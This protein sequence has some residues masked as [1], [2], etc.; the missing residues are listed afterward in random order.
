[1]CFNFLSFIDLFVYDIYHTNFVLSKNTV[2]SY[3]FELGYFLTEFPGL[4]CS[5]SSLSHWF[6][7]LTCYGLFILVFKRVSEAMYGIYLMTKFMILYC[8]LTSVVVCSFLTFCST[9]IET[10]FFCSLSFSF[11]NFL[12]EYRYPQ[13]VSFLLCYLTPLYV[14]FSL[15]VPNVLCT[16]FHH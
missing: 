9:H 1:M 10:D 2:L 8:V 4:R 7:S 12:K 3:I 16:L 14:T 6:S 5:L 11:I 13:Y 15:C